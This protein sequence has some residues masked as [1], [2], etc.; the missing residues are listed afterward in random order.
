MVLIDVAQKANIVQPQKKIST[1]TLKV[2]SE[3]PK[4]FYSFRVTGIN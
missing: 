3:T 1:A 2:N 4:I